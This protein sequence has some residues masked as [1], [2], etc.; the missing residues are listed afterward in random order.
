MAFS[1]S[2]FWDGV[3]AARRLAEDGDVELCRDALKSAWQGAS[4]SGIAGAE[5]RQAMILKLAKAYGVEL[6]A[7]SDSGGPASGG[8]TAKVSLVTACRNRNENLKVAMA[9][10]TSCP[11]IAEIIIVDWSS[12]V[13][14]ADDLKASGIDDE[15][16]RI[17]RVEGEPRWILSYAFNLGF[18]SARYPCIL[19]ADADIVLEVDFFDRNVLGPKTFIAGNWRNTDRDQAFV[20]G[21]FYTWRDALVEIGGFNEYITTYGWDDEELYARLLEAGVAR[22][23]VAEKSIYHLP[24]DDA[25]RTDQPTIGD[26]LPALDYLK[27][28]TD[29]LIRRNRII[30]CLMPSWNSTRQPVRYHALNTEGPKATLRRLPATG[31]VVPEAVEREANLAAARELLA[32]RFND[33]C[34]ALSPEAVE[35]LTTEHAWPD[36]SLEQVRS[37]TSVRNASTMRAPIEAG[38]QAIPLE[39]G[40]RAEC[41]KLYVDAQHGLGNRMRAIG[42]AAA[43]ARAEGR[44]LIIVWRADHHCQCRFEDLFDYDGPVLSDYDVP[45][46]TDAMDLINYMEIE[47]GAAKG[48]P[49]LPRANR[50]IYFRSAF[51]MNHPASTW[52]SENE[53]IQS[54]IPTAAVADLIASVQ[55][56]NEIG[57]HVRM[58]G[59]PRFEHLAWESPDNWTS[60]AHSTVAHWRSQSH[61]DRFILRLQQLMEVSEVNSIFVAADLTAT[62]KQFT[63][64]F[65]TKITYLP[66]GDDTRSQAQLRYALADASLL[67]RSNRFLGS[68]WSSFSE[69]AMRLSKTGLEAEMSGKD[70]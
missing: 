4:L 11:Q 59:G 47:R 1:Y 2:S 27:T 20:N 56:T 14:V 62:Y 53:F 70:F 19:K 15:R 18:R 21:F 40:P 57:V 52:P 42:S 31:H 66:R 41:R 51:V 29:Y 49:V 33:D 5:P 3:A 38:G 17:V 39:P 37:T 48:V 24:H 65:G 32:W 12:D 36:L 67:S 54:L 45:P 26:T 28:R 23:D 25:A 43:V 50:D 16:V 35:A 8:E 64:R 69:L 7:L 13:P 60:K 44:E 46:S 6:T 22:K 58:A 68:T 9:S 10:W 55:T 63:D 34:Y 61:A 30:A